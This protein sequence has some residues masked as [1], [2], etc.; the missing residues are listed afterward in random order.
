MTPRKAPARERAPT[1]EEIERF[2]HDPVALR[3][4]AELY[5]DGL[6]QDAIAQA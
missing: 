1:R 4:A 3:R 2:L 6:I 5:I